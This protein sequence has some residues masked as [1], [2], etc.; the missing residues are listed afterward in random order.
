MLKDLPRLMLCAPASGQGKTTLSLALLKALQI[1]GQKPVAFKCGP[2]YIDPMFH[3]RVLGLPS[4]N[5]DLF[6]SD[7]QTVCSLLAECGS[8]GNIALIEGAMGYYDG[9]GTTE[10]ASAYE[11]ASATQT[12]SILIISAKGAA[13]SLAAMVRGFKEFRIPSHVS[14]VILNRCSKPLYER[15]AP[16]LERETGL[17]V[18]GFL[19]ELLQCS[20]QSRHLG[21]VTADEIAD[22]EQKLEAL[23]EAAAEN[24]D[25]Q[26]LLQIAKAAPPLDYEPQVYIPLS[27]TV[28]VAA[29]RDDAFCFY[30]DETL[31]LFE[32]FGAKITFFSPLNDTKLP[33]NTNALY[34]GGGYPELYAERLSENKAMLK[35]ISQAI[36]D[37][38]P[39]LAECG[40][41]LY[42]H[43]RL[44][45]D[46]GIFHP[47]VGKISGDATKGTRLGHFGYATLTARNDNL[48][49]KAGES[50]K[51][52]EFHYWQSEN[53]GD[54]CEAKKPD[55]RSW[56]C[57]HSTDNLFA[58]FPHLYLKGNTNAAKRFLTAAAAYGE[59]YGF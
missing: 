20:L 59:R 22:L 49:C 40:G 48:L 33:Q 57:V 51:S 9:V 23:G 52:H 3:R 5:L 1:M 53:C 44:Q 26:R 31:A 42:L 29:A 35:S 30:Y 27:S 36:S 15:I 21:L 55:G 8:R 45:D 54:S 34:L 7:K 13:L 17:P 43:E 12:P 38:M 47:M 24:I 18:L 25:F 2:D 50:L 14:G 58:G 10:K 32:Q 56:D 39:C 46:K 41:F 4:N 6:L 19:P 11:V 37:K 16:V 28:S